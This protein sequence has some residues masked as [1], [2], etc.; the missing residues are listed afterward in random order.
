MKGIGLHFGHVFTGLGLI[1]IIR[2]YYDKQIGTYYTGNDLTTYT[3]TLQRDIWFTKGT[4]KI[5]DM[6]H[7]QL[8]FG[9]SRFYIADNGCQIISRDQNREKFINALSVGDIV[10][11]S[12]ESALNETTNDGKN[13]VKI[14]GLNSNGNSVLKSEEVLNADK[15]DIRNWNI[16]GITLIMLG[17]ITYYFKHRRI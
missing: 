4:Q 2:C 14:V 15:K 3:D 9:K 1:L 16:G 17:G 11:V 13:S 10:T 12:Y 5:S 6:Y 8:A 7:I